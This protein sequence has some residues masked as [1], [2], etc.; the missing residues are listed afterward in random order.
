VFFVVLTDVNPDDKNLFQVMKDLQHRLPYMEP[1]G[2]MGPRI[3]VKPKNPGKS[4]AKT[5][6]I[7]DTNSGIR[8]PSALNSEI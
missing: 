5:K 3:V 8:D 7:L 1:R 2:A 6:I 4:N